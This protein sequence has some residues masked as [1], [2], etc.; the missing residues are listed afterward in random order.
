MEQV[1]MKKIKLS[2]LTLSIDEDKDWRIKRLVAL[3]RFKSLD[4]PSIADEIGCSVDTA[5]RNIVPMLENKG[6][7]HKKYTHNNKVVVVTNDEVEI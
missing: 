1:T 3:M 2:D 4:Y 7:V 6:L 5:R